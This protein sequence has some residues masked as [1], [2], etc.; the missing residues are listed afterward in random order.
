MSESNTNL[1]KEESYLPRLPHSPGG[2]SWSKMHATKIISVGFSWC[3]ATVPGFFQSAESSDTTCLGWK[4]R[5]KGGT[6]FQ[7]F[8]L[9]W[10]FPGWPMQPSTCV[11]GHLGSHQ[12]KHSKQ[13]T[14]SASTI[15]CKNY[16]M[17][18]QLEQST[19]IKLLPNL[20]K[21]SPKAGAPFLQPD[22]FPGFFFIISSSRGVLYYP[23]PK[24]PI[25]VF[26][27]K[28]YRRGKGDLRRKWTYEVFIHMYETPWWW[29]N[30]NHMKHHL[31]YILSYLVL[32]KI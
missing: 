14:P 21:P 6:A 15:S 26:A 3:H 27:M 8:L 4:A 25:T 11:Q 24:A 31:V 2:S 18:T 9:L 1:Q 32:N 10:P 29:E 17:D 19:F 5:Y 30:W 13:G 7:H 28:L 20:A 22:C 23:K 16:A 12:Q